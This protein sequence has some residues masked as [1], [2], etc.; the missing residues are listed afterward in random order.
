LIETC[1]MP[2]G[3]R[4]SYGERSF[5]CPRAI[6]RTLLRSVAIPCPL[7]VG[8]ILR[9]FAQAL[10]PCWY[11]GICAALDLP[12]HAGRLRYVRSGGAIAL[13]TSAFFAFHSEAESISAKKRTPPD[14]SVAIGTPSR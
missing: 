9:F 14:S 2:V 1:A 5:H 11:L 4:L 12:S 13:L 6:E 8:G 7:S 3:S 10:E